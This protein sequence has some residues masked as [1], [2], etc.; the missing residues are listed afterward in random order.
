VQ[1]WRSQSL[2]LNIAINGD[3]QQLLPNLSNQNTCPLF[4]ENA[5]PFPQ[6]AIFPSGNLGQFSNCLQRDS[7]AITAL[8]DLVTSP[9]VKITS[10]PPL[11]RSQ[12]LALFANQYPDFSLQLQGQNSQQ[13]VKAG[14]AQVGATALP[15]LQDWIFQ[16]NQK[17]MTWG[18][19]IGL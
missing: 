8:E 19:G 18:Q 3:A 14:F 13:L 4:P 6:R 1:S 16:A 17:T 12:Y 9:L 10:T 2:L 5:P 7:L 11:T 15:I